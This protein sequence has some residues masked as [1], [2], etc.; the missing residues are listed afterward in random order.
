MWKFGWEQ[1][2]S[3]C[4]SVC[5][6]NCFLK[7]T[8]LSI[9]EVSRKV[10]KAGSLLITVGNYFHSVLDSNDPGDISSPFSRHHSSLGLQKGDS[11]LGPH[12]N[13]TPGGGGI[14]SSVS[15]KCISCANYCCSPLVNAVSRRDT[16]LSSSWYYLPWWKKSP[17]HY[18][19]P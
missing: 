16:Y 7:Y 11:M 1:R 3:D 5:S 19:L 14:L 8:P 2:V 10:P 9:A 6:E 4:C 15:N 17:P 13:E 18:L 12:Y